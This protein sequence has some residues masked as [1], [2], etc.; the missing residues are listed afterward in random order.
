MAAITLW[1]NAL[2]IFAENQDNSRLLVKITK[3]LDAEDTFVQLL[4][5]FRYNHLWQP[6]A[7]QMQQYQLQLFLYETLTLTVSYYNSTSVSL[8][9]S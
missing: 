5:N 2:Q 9:I 7:V 1:E 3:R 4:S 8:S 6:N